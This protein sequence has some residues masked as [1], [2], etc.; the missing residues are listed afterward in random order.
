MG[1]IAN[2]PRVATIATMPSRV[3]TLEAVVHAIR[4]QVSKFFVYLDHF[5]E[6]PPFLRDLPGIELRRAEDHGDL[7]SASRFLCL[8]E[9]T[10]PACVFCVDDD[11][12]YPANYVE[13]LTSLLDRN[14]GNVL[15]G[16]HGRIF[17]PPHNSY[18]H[19]AH[20]I[21]FEQ[22][23]EKPTYVHEVGAGTCAF[24]SDKLLLS[25]RLWP[26]TDMSDIRVAI[27]AQKLRLPRIV[28]GRRSNWLRQYLLKDAPDTLW[29]R[30]QRDDSETTRLM[31]EL[32]GLYA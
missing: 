12:F 21:H 2:L 5:D 10:S 29:A 6:V 31:H 26:R 18:V 25:P 3:K 28:V 4:S 9:L 30:K 22:S 11:I 17:L 24:V 7:H 19:D 16:V 20:P 27:E 1:D 8:E 14:A 15:V 32:L 13:R 23:L